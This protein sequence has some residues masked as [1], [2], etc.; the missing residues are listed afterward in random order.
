MGGNTYV[1]DSLYSEGKYDDG[2]LEE[3]SDLYKKSFVKESDW[4][5]LY[6]C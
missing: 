6:F 4:L 3:I 5:I 2:I 1:L